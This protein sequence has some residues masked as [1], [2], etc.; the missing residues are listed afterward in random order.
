[1]RLLIIL[2]LV[3]VGA[4]NRASDSDAER[5]EP[6]ISAAKPER[7]AAAASS[8]STLAQRDAFPPP[9]SVDDER[10]S[11]TDRALTRL[12]RANISKQDALANVAKTVRISASDGVVTLRGTVRTSEERVEMARIAQGSDGV[13]EIDNQLE[14]ADDTQQ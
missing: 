8:D 4:C 14:L 6:D 7:A 3:G 12:V 9:Q 2:L 1:M 10:G 13:R 11:D 5:R